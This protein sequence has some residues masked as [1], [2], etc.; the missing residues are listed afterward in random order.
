MRHIRWSSLGGLFVVAAVACTGGDEGDGGDDGILLAD[1]DGAAAVALREPV[2]EAFAIG[3]PT[4]TPPGGCDG[5][6]EFVKVD[7]QGVV[8]P[9]LN[10]P[11]AAD[12][13]EATTSN[14]VVRGAGM[15]TTSGGDQAFW[16]CLLAVP[17]DSGPVRCLSKEAGVG[18]SDPLFATGIAT[19]GEEVFFTQYAA[20]EG[21]HRLAYWDGSSSDL[22][23]RLQ[24]SDTELIQPFIAAASAITPN[25]CVRTL[26]PAFTESGMLCGD[27]YATNPGWAPVVSSTALTSFAFATMVGDSHVFLGAESLDLATLTTQVVTPYQAFFDEGK[28][29]LTADDGSII[30]L[31][32]SSIVR[33]AAPATAEELESAPDGGGVWEVIIGHNDVGFALGGNDLRR[34]DLTSAVVGTSNY[35]SEI[36]MLEITDVAF[37]T[38]ERIRLEGTDG[39]GQP[40]TVLVDTVTGD[41][42]VGSAGVPTFETIQS[43]E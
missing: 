32:G 42:T 24:L 6:F 36:N 5:E 20:A 11:F 18:L 10:Q 33:A 25:A 27:P 30:G 37:T 41:V 8:T 22:Q 34:I 16:C 17:K 39:T 19:R 31:S 29:R 7:D 13:I 43:V 21:F 38:G 2:T 12:W 14:I 4:P 1:M 28:P 40:V 9:V 26:D 3:A 35:L 15:V 23:F